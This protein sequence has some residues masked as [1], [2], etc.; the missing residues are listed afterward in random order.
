MAVPTE[1]L[2]PRADAEAATEEHDKATT[3]VAHEMRPASVRL[4][5]LLLL[6]N[7]F[8][9][10]TILIKEMCLNMFA[11]VIVSPLTVFAVPVLP[12]FCVSMCG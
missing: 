6:L 9:Q 10:Q 3:H 12:R 11:A 5:L 4:R 8:H 2:S 1:T 7:L